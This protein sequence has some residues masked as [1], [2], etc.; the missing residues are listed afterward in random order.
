MKNNYIVLVD[1]EEK[2][3]EEFKSKIAELG[4]KHEL[5]YF[6]D[7]AGL[8]DALTKIDPS[9]IKF[10]ISG[11]DLDGNPADNLVLKAYH[12]L[13]ER[14]YLPPL[15]IHLHKFIPSGAGLGGGSAD[16]SFML[17][18]LVEYFNLK[19]DLQELIQ[20]AAKIGSDC[21]F[22]ISNETSFASGKG[23]ILRPVFPELKDKYIVIIKPP[24][25]VNTKEAYAGIQPSEPLHKLS[26]LIELPVKEWQDKINNDFELPVFQRFPEL[27][28]IKQSLYEL[29]ALYASMSGSGSAVYGIFESEPDIPEL[30]KNYF[31]WKCLK[32]D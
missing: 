6:K 5:L 16:G 21:A 19:I 17:K 15:S 13:K 28:L 9:E 23:E 14:F 26:E 7:V 2:F 4:I 30:P 27:R 24:Y 29:G 31:V 32:V 20:L 8:V 18:G 12:L 1:D 11:I 22:F 3:K 10:I 25:A